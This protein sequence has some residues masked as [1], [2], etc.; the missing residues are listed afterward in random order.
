M[1]RDICYVAFDL[2]VTGTCVKKIF[3]KNAEQRCA[4]R[5]R[6][7]SSSSDRRIR[8]DGSCTHA[9]HDMRVRN[10]MTRNDSRGGQRSTSGIAVESTI[11]ATISVPR[12]VSV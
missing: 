2:P 11:G 4:S 10:V 12:V 6:S 7:S 1:I 3:F 5:H 8:T 9:T